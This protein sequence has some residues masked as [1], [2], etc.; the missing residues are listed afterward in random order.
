MTTG[1]IVIFL[2]ADDVLHPDTAARVLQAFVANDRMSRVHYPLIVIDSA[3]RPTGDTIPRPPHRLLD[4]DAVPMLL[5][6]PD[7]IAWQP[8]SGNAFARRALDAIMP[9][10]EEE[11]RICA[12]YYLSNLTPLHGPVGA[13]DAPGGGYRVHGGN[14]HFAPTQ[15]LAGI[16][17]NVQRTNVTHGWLIEHCRRTGRRGPGTD[18]QSVRSVT[19][20]ANRIISLRLDRAHHPLGDDTRTGLLALGIR[21]AA[22]RRDVGVARR[23]SF[24][25]WFIAAAIA[26]VACL[27]VVMR[28][29]VR[30]SGGTSRIADE[31]G[32][33][34]DDQQRS[35]PDS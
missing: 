30:L 13:L 32:H 27:H 15:T 8:T 10:P 4:G 17:D 18:P 29:Y 21:S 3:G 23:V 28:P 11:Y 5:R 2:D 34:E 22:A 31:P 33:D 14:R 6:C 24:A 26:P 20:A 35:H 19:A 12:D 16:R 7:D 25:L 1:D 9:M